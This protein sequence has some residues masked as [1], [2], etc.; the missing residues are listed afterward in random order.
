M[1]NIVKDFLDKYNLHTNAESRF[2]DVV[3]E[4]GELGKEI[5]KGNKYGKRS[6]EN[7]E[8]FNDEMGDCLFSLLALCC[9]ANISAED[10]F[11]GALAKYEKRFTEKQSIDSGG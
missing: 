3:S 11:K 1:Q 10:A 6:H 8:G 2:I 9:E 5:L 4:V 7:S